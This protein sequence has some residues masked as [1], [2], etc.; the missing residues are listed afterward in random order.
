[1]QLRKYQQDSIDAVYKYLGDNNTGNPCIVIPTG[2]GKTPVLATI[3]RDV[4]TKWNGRVLILAHVK[5]LLQQA[6]DKL[7]VICP[8]VNAGVY[9]AGLNSRDTDNPVIV[10]GIQSVYKKAHKLGAFDIIL[11]DEA[12]L[13]PVAGEGRYRTFLDDTM[14]ISPHTRIIG[15]TATPYRL[16]TGMIC[17]EDNILNNICYE[18]G[19]EELINEGYLS[20]LVSVNGKDRP[21]TTSLHKRG[22]EF[23]PAEVQELMDDDFVVES[24]VCDFLDK[25]ADRKKTLVFC[26]G[27]KHAEHVVE[28]MKS[29]YGIEAGIV[30]GDTPAHER[31]ELIHRFREGD[32]SY[33][34]NINVLTIGFDAPDVDCVVLLSCT[35]SVGRYYQM[36]GRGFRIADGKKNCLILDYGGNVERHGPIDKLEVDDDGQN[37][38]EAKGEALVKEC[39]KCQELSALSVRECPGCGHQFGEDKGPSHDVKAGTALILSGGQVSSI[40][41]D[42]SGTEYNIHTKRGADPSDP[43][44]VKVT[45]NIGLFETKCEW[46][47]PEHKGF[48]RNKFVSWWTDRCD[49]PVP[50]TAEETANIASSGAL[51]KT[52]E[53]TVETRGGDKFDRIVNYKLGERPEVEDGF[54]W[55]LN[56]GKPQIN[57]D[58][59][60]F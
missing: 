23:I 41:Y 36:V 32:L 39:P 3:C 60:P 20:P 27:V 25:S 10:A 30:T 57:L 4:V 58:D 29:H 26:S 7:N 24:A 17:G 42:V 13:I 31:A 34:V 12:H 11:V 15:L 54:D 45:Y 55:A 47:C 5:E 35:A 49:L 14:K 28:V 48:A 33:L 38:A 21:D 56:L 16:S 44:T 40:K 52:Y 8:E 1:M 9:S 53:I 46:I 59:L 43:K 37:K 2:G 22:G 18:V 51:S 50:D 6:A 19:V